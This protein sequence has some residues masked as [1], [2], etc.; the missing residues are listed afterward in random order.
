[1]PKW[2]RKTM[3]LK[4]RRIGREAYTCKVTQRTQALCKK[5]HF[6][7]YIEDPNGDIIFTGSSGG[8]I[9]NGITRKKFKLMAMDQI[10]YHELYGGK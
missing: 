6:R 10:N 8:T 2:I 3:T 5:I 4:L 9:T 1:M 7:W